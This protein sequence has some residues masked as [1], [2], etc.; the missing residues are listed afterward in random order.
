MESA[1]L[2][3]VDSIFSTIC[4]IETPEILQATI[5]HV[6]GRSSQKIPESLRKELAFFGHAEF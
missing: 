6:S 5:S 1:K 2:N 3:P 4:S